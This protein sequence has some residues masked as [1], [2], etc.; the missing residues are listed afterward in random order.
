[1]F[2]MCRAALA[3]SLLWIPC[4]TASA[5]IPMRIEATA[6]QPDGSVVAVGKSSAANPDM[7][8]TI[9]RLHA[10]GSL[11]TAFGSGGSVEFSAGPD[12]SE[13]FATAATVQADG[14]IV[15]AVVRDGMLALLRLGADGTP[16][17]SFGTGTP[18][19]VL[20]GMSRASVQIR[21]LIPSDSGMVLAVG[22]AF[23]SDAATWLP[24]LIR[25]DAQGSPDST[26][27]ADG[28]RTYAIAAG[29]AEL[30]AAIALPDGG[31]V[32]AGYAR[33]SA[34]SE[35]RALIAKFQANGDLDPAF[36]NA[37]STTTTSCE[38]GFDS[39]AFTLTLEPLSS[40]LVL[41][42][43][44]YVDWSPFSAG[45]L[46][47]FHGDGSADVDFGAGGR[48]NTPSLLNRHSTIVS[49]AMIPETADLVLGESA[50]DATGHSLF[51]L[52]RFSLP[53]AFTDW[54]PML[55]PLPLE[56]G[57][58]FELKAV[59]P[60]A[61]GEFL[62]IGARES[63]TGDTAYRARHFLDNGELDTDFPTEGADD[64]PNSWNVSFYAEANAGPGELHQSNIVRISGINVPVSI[65]VSRGMY[66]IG[67]TGTFRSDTTTIVNGQAVCVRDNAADTPDTTTSVVLYVGAS[68]F[69]YDITTGHASDTAI[70]TRPGSASS[71]TAAFTY[72][73]TGWGETFVCRLDGAPFAAC[74]ASGI[75]YTNLPAGTHAFDVATVGVWG[76]DPTPASYTWDSYVLPDTV[77]VSKPSSPSGVSMAFG[78][79]SSSGA[80]FEC[81]LDAGAFA[82]CTSPKSYSN[83]AGGTHSFTVRARNP[84]GYDPTPAGY[85]WVVD[86]VLPD[87]TL[88]SGPAGVTMATTATFT[89]RSSKTPSTFECKIDQGTFAPCV[90]G[91]TYSN[92]ARTIHTIAVRAMDAVGNIDPTPASYS[93][94]VN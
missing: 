5:Q 24:A 78:F 54:G 1:M 61:T 64:T 26:F 9:S 14:K 63:S 87:T 75:T 16:D 37:G 92:L 44:C 51:A 84:A 38:A 4:F 20:E 17:L 3:A 74:P 73:S 55:A 71:T 53:A 19:M 33:A 36:A 60:D 41:A 45:S 49:S 83:L 82:A 15:I 39:E 93:W 85:S 43:R 88:L 76:Q 12:S 31:V 28:M 29:G 77:L 52:L 21:T 8:I 27:G 56:D 81:K 80:T 48:A 7:R 59:Y 35:K 10:D 91:V 11:D 46:W 70:V 62:S 72:S 90:S 18:G 32:A 66:S 42:G 79:S 86:A 67:C 57:V 58:D 94:R 50:I 69:E 68:Q 22:T 47:V 25:Y 40:R 65:G 13:F 89:F 23:S 30:N 34:G 6:R 2:A